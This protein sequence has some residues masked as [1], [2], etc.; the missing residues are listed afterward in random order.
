MTVMV[1]VGQCWIAIMSELTL[2][3]TLYL[4]QFHITLLLSLLEWWRK[5]T[6]F[7]LYKERNICGDVFALNWFL[8]PP[9]FVNQLT[10]P[11]EMSLFRAKMGI[12][13][14]R[15]NRTP[16]TCVLHVMNIWN[17][18]TFHTQ[19]HFYTKWYDNPTTSWLQHRAQSVEILCYIINKH[20]QDHG[21]SC[22]QSQICITLVLW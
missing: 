3:L 6:L 22:T 9:F 19:V 12:S 2:N 7:H 13:V 18:W 16:S 14:F 17:I 8:F 1:V 10:Y 20:N 15:G 21:I 4:P 11:I 5:L